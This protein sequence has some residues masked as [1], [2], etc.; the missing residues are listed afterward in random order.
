M[1]LLLLWMGGL[2]GLVAAFTTGFWFTVLF[3]IEMQFM[4]FYQ[5]D[6][7]EPSNLG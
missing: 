6:W 5:D 4:E 3:W 1:W 2:I 7:N